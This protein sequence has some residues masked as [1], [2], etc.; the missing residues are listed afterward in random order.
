M[1]SDYIGDLGRIRCIIEYIFTFVSSVVSWK[2]ASQSIEALST[3]G[4]EYMTITEA[5]KK[6]SD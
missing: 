6:L 1:D 4:V 2:L 3:I 5:V